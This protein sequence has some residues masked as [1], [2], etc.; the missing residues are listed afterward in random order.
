MNLYFFHQKLKLIIIKKK[1]KRKLTLT[2]S[3]K[4]EL[5]EKN[6]ACCRE[7]VSI[8]SSILSGISKIQFK[9]ERSEIN[10][11]DKNAN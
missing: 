4:L 10:E 3:L 2:Y 9:T 11:K 8:N 1:K 5:K 7:F 6:R